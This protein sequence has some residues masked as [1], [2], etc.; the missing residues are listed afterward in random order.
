[1][2]IVFA[3]PKLFDDVVA[4]FALDA[5]ALVPP[6]TPTPNVFGWRKP[7][8]QMRTSHRITW[9]PG[10]DESGE[11]GAIEGARFP[12]RNPR[13]LA[14]LTEV[15][16]VYVEA[17]DVTAPEDERA[18][19]QAARELF[20]AW[21]RAVHLAAYGT[22]KILRSSWHGERTVR[23]RGAAIRLLCTIDAMVPDAAS[24]IAPVDVRA[25]IEVAELNHTETMESAPV[26]P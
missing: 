13:P 22:F 2:S 8:E 17:F 24:E 10:D 3:L 25:E 16:T 7:A 26:A 23:R 14:T 6:V 19:Y 5:A 21:Y 1:M 4:R 18:Q 20:D 11:L 12:G 15:F 9:V